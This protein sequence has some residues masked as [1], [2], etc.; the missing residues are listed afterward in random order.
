MTTLKCNCKITNNIMDFEKEVKNDRGLIENMHRM[1]YYYKN[2]IN[3]C[4]NCKSK[5]R[6]FND[7]EEAKLNIEQQ[8]FKLLCE[9]PV[10]EPETEPDTD[11]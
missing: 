11:I 2:Y 10:N 6:I 3:I 7:L 1:S 9:E 4:G 8:Q 5:A